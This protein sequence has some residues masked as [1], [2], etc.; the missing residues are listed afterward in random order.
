[1]V[2]EGPRSMY[3]SVS[4]HLRVGLKERKKITT[5]SRQYALRTLKLMKKTPSGPAPLP[6][7][8]H[9]VAQSS[10]SPP[11]TEPLGTRH[12]ELTLLRGLL[13]GMAARRLYISFERRLE[14]AVTGRGG[15]SGHPSTGREGSQ[16]RATLDVLTTGCIDASFR[17]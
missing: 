4:A 1:M 8:Q 10:T 11:G 16:R 7:Q 13:D 12:R 2:P 15:G 6:P 3:S 5:K 14:K 9:A 17:G